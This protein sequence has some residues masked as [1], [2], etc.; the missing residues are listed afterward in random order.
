MLRNTFQ[1]IVGFI[2][3]IIL[4][5]LLFIFSLLLFMQVIFSIHCDIY[6]QGIH[7][8]SHEHLTFTA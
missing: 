1:M 8:S 3:I 2:I 7:G 5:F 6:V 4:V